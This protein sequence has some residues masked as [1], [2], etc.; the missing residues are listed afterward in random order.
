M[1]DKYIQIRDRVIIAGQTSGGVWYIKELPAES[2]K[3]LERLVGECNRICNRYNKK[4]KVSP[5]P[6]S[7]EKKSK[8]RM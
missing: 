5:T 8:V 1:L 2:T 6:P 7:K 3:E 4:E